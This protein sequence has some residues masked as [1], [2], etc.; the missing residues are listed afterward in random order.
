MP[1]PYR[2]ARGM[3]AKR[4]GAGRPGQAPP[5]RANALG[6]APP[7][8]VPTPATPPHAD[9]RMR[10]RI[11]LPHGR[12][13]A[14][15]RLPPLCTPPSRALPGRTTRQAMTA[16]FR[17]SIPPQRAHQAPRPRSCTLPARPSASRPVC[18]SPRCMIPRWQASLRRP[19][20]APSPSAVLRRAPDR[21]RTH[22]GP[23]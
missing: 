14:A 5:V 20:S 6:S 23:P 18:A 8:R 13:P 7:L 4:C 19:L 11:P 12:A 2:D 9:E 16:N 3:R 1:P 17:A 10:P 22:R 15:A 21:A